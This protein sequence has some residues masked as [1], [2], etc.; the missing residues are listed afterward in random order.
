MKDPPRILQDLKN[1]LL[2]SYGSFSP[3][4][5]G[6]CSSTVWYDS[7]WYALICLA[8][9]PPTVPLLDRCGVCWKEAIGVILA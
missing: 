3:S 6:Q 2:M 8:F 1:V 7:G 5:M 4:G 9:P